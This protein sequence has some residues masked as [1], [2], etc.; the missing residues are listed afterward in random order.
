MFRSTVPFARELD[1]TTPLICYQ[2]AL[3]RDPVSGATVFHQALPLAVALDVI[4]A[5]R[6]DG[7]YPNAYLNDN[8]YVSEIN[9]GTDY[10]ARLNGG[11][12]VNPVG[13]LASFLRREGGDP[14]KLSVVLDDEGTTDVVVAR[15]RARFGEQIYTTKSHP[16]FA[17]ALH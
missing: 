10:Y 5:L 1:I 3:I 16:L 15:L 8:L 17:E 12:P 2:G 6:A 7:L 13:D 9:P 14:T 11:I 4:G